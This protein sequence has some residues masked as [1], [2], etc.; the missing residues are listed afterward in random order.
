MG[1]RFARS[2]GLERVVLVVTVIRRTMPTTLG[3]G[4]LPPIT[5]TRTTAMLSFRSSHLSSREYVTLEDVFDAYYSCRKHKRNTSSALEFEQDFILGCH[6]LWQ[7]LNEMTYEIGTSTAFCVSYPKVREVFAANFRDRIVHHLIVNKFSYWFEKNML[8]CAF[9]C[10]E[11]KGSLY[12]VRFLQASM[13]DIGKS[14][15][16]AKCDI[17]GFFMS[18][19]R[20]IL[21][22]E[23]E[24]IVKQVGEKDVEWW[25]W[26]I[27]KVIMN[28]PE[29]DCIVK[30]D[31]GLWKKLPKNKSLFN[32]NGKGLPI[33]NLTSQVFANIYMSMFD[34]WIVE[35]LGTEGRYGRYVDDFII[36]HKDKD[37]LLGLA[38][39]SKVWLSKNLNLAMHPRKMS[40]QQVGKG[41]RFT[42]VFIKGD[43]LYPSK[44]LVEGTFK[45]AA[46]WKEREGVKLKDF[47]RRMNSRLGLMIHY[48]SYN[49]RRR[50]W[51]TLGY[52]EG[53]ILINH[54][55]I[56][57]TRQ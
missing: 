50:I 47:V 48:K 15:W 51:R 57:T 34:R 38:E 9:A 31:K 55:K 2:K 42:G 5:T 3:T 43:C 14:S 28:R 7:E 21:Y 36:M 33:G 13:K 39:E 53:I 35:R 25:L 45:L 18:I 44:R 49:L 56:K 23:I 32:S 29:R 52:Y 41:V 30:G 54:K 6:K 11:G 16:Y 17:S 10:R 22:K 24:R 46:E 12:G 40:V 20:N 26:L 27:R 4:Q 1:Y 19:D 8:D 37:F